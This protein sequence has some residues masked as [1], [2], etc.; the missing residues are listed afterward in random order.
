MKLEKSISLIIG[1]AIAIIGIILS[2]T[3]R[4]YIYENNLN[5]FHL[6]DTIGSLI[7]VPCSVLVFYS[8]TNKQS[9][10]SL[11]IYSTIGF[12]LYEILSLSKLHGTFDL[13][14]ICAIITGAVFTY[15]ALN[16]YKVFRKKHKIKKQGL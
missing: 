7:C 15:F 11:I 12:I 9:V 4:V 8:M 5:D 13:Y 6:A 2:S 10:H 1:L 3:Y 16:V 14:D